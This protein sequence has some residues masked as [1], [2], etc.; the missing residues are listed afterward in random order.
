MKW[1]SEDS[2]PL[3]DIEAM[4]EKIEKEAG[5][6]RPISFREALYWDAQN[7]YMMGYSSEQVNSYVKFFLQIHEKIKKSPPKEREGSQRERD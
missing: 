7:L 1:D 5:I 3:D 6:E 2:N 4:K